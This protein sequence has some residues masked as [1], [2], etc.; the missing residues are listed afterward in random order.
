M[1]IGGY[2]YQPDE[3]K[4]FDWK[5]GEGL[6]GDDDEDK[7][8]ELTVQLQDWRKKNI[9][10]PYNNWTDEEKQTFTVS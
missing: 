7:V 6:S 3:N 8:V 4:K 1:C 9:S 5:A 2:W 10:T